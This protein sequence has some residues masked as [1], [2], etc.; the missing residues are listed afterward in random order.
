MSRTQ[1]PGL[2]AS[3]LVLA[4]AFL[5]GVSPARLNAQGVFL[6]GPAEALLPTVTPSFRFLAAG[7]GP[8]RPLEIRLQIS[9][10]RD[11][12]GILVDSTFAS[13]DTSVVIQLTTPLPPGRNVFWRA[14]VR[15]LAGPAY[16]S[17]ITGPKAVPQWVTLITPNSPTGNRFDTRRPRFVWQS[18]PVTPLAGKWHYKLELLEVGQPKLGASGLTD[19]TYIPPVDLQANTSYRWILEASLGTGA[20]Q[21]VN[22][23]GSF[24]IIDPELPTTTL[25]YQ[26]FP[27]PFPS[28]SSG[29]TCFWFDVGGTG[30][31]VTLD[32]LDLRGN[33]V[34]RLI[35]VNGENNDFEPGRYGRGVAGS[36]S[37]CDGRYVW[38][39]SADDGRN[40]APGVYIARFRTES[41]KQTFRRI[42]F[43]GR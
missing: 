6:E 10:T 2:T 37:N 41:G 39:G 43:N 17:A 28:S 21:R 31:R 4:A 15:A 9:S 19:T 25:L 16:E 42:L 34:R 30:D 38:D 35:P 5:T 27:N 7:L 24:V 22:S 11:F 32:I 26:N 36:E 14:R 12:V 40:V 23:L 3:L 8:A 13:M 33:M 18:P 29:N 1:G 20:V